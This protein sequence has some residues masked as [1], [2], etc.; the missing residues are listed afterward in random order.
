MSERCACMKK[1]LSLSP[2]SPLK[3]PL[4]R[5]SSGNIKSHFQFP[6]SDAKF[7]Q[8][9]SCGRRPL[10]SNAAISNENLSVI[11]RCAQRCACTANKCDSL[12]RQPKARRR[13][14][15]LISSRSS[16][17]CSNRSPKHYTNN[18][19]DL[20][21]VVTKFDTVIHNNGAVTPIARP[22]VNQIGHH[23]TWGNGNSAPA[24]CTCNNGCHGAP[25]PYGNYDVPPSAIISKVCI[26][27]CFL[28]PSPMY[29]I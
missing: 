7:R 22:Q 29:I 4:H 21:P 25:N 16:S 10:P 17:P 26:F 2:K 11:H 19:P 6:D 13:L 20:C 27:I 8:P 3:S 12:D 24:V 1:G 23:R 28:I 5:L 14:D 18:R 9:C 15:H